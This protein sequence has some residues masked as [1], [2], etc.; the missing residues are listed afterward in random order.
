MSFKRYFV[1]IM[2]KFWLSCCS[3]IE[4]VYELAPG[5]FVAWPDKQE[6][7]KRPWICWDPNHWQLK[8]SAEEYDINVVTSDDNDV[9]GALRVND[10]NAY[11]SEPAQQLLDHKI[12]PWHR[13]REKII[14]S[15]YCA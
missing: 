14:I 2:R 1:P 7:D 4:T 3:Q 15:D 10:P 11:R 9:I 12:N 13:F 8:Q 6:S 5:V